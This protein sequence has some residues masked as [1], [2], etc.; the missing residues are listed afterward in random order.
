MK[1][2]RPGP[3]ARRSSCDYGPCGSP[4]GS[5][6]R[7]CG[8]EICPE[9][10]TR[11]LWGLNTVLH[12]A[13]AVWVS[14]CLGARV[15]ECRRNEATTPSTELPRKPPSAERRPAS[16][17][18]D[19]RRGRTVRAG[20][21]RNGRPGV[22]IHPAEDRALREVCRRA[23][24]DP[25]ASFHIRSNHQRSSLRQRPPTTRRRADQAAPTLGQS[26]RVR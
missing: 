7:L 20:R 24:L 6:V 23:G 1:F 3:A 22:N 12:R 9:I 25:P 11:M 17:R 15:Q 19:R 10:R 21:R 13:C 16:P 4:H 18:A 5:G 14:S 26:K 2:T 8:E